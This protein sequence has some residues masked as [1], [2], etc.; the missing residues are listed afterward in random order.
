MTLA[1]P[2]STPI[3]GEP[4]AAVLVQTTTLA[5]ALSDVPRNIHTDVDRVTETRPP[6][7]L[8]N[9]VPPLVQPV[10]TMRT[11]MSPYT[12]IQPRLSVGSG[13]LHTA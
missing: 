7:A 6:L 13:S 2:M 10:P 4:T 12:P 1:S 3:P 11:L 8:S 9:P 5:T